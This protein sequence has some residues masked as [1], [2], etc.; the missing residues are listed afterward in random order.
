[1]FPLLYCIALDVL[2]IQALAVPCEHVFSSGK[3]T[4]TAWQNSL[5]PNAMEILQILKFAF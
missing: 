3:D 1:T 4:E 5:S 2:P